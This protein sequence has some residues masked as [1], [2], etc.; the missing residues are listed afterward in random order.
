MYIDVTGIKLMS[1]RALEAR[2][3]ENIRYITID[4]IALMLRSFPFG[5]TSLI[6]NSVV[7]AREDVLSIIFPSPRSH[8]QTR[9]AHY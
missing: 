9:H 6:M 2:A 8:S 3:Q 5:L 7:G 4:C 1:M